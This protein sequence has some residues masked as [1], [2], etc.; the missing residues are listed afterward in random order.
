MHNFMESGN[1]LPIWEVLFGKMRLT[2]LLWKLWSVESIR[3][4]ARRNKNVALKWGNSLLEEG[5]SLLPF[6]PL[7]YKSNTVLGSVLTEMS[8]ERMMS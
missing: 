3:I 7:E 4:M 5:E 8:A 2:Q 6:K 1:N